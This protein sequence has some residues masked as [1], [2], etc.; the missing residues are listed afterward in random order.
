MNTILE[1]RRCYDS[2]RA[3]SQHKHKIKHDKTTM[4]LELVYA[5]EAYVN[6]IGLYSHIYQD[7]KLT[8]IL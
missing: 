1:K 3:P 5:G 4:Q 7:F 6:L 8:C 2:R